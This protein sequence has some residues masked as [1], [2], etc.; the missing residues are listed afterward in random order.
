M[1]RTKAPFSEAVKALMEMRNLSY[2]RLSK[3]TKLADDTGKGL[4]SGYIHLLAND[5][6]N[7]TPQNMQLLAAALRVEPTHF[8]EYRQYLAAREARILEA[9]YGLDAIISHLQNFE[10]YQRKH[11]EQKDK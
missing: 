1:Q 2:E 7:P 3:A 9:E 10:A 8:A 5:K 11:K 4:S 6:R